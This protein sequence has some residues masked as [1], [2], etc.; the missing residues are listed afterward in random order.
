MEDTLL[1]S[2]AAAAFLGITVANLLMRKKS[3]KWQFLAPIKV[4]GK[5]YFSNENLRKSLNPIPSD[6]NLVSI[7]YKQMVSRLKKNNRRFK[8][9]IFH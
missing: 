2:K 6:L 1:D 8:W 7:K 4:H 5:L 3:K 9:K